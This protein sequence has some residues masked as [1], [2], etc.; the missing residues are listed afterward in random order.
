[1]AGRCFKVEGHYF[2]DIE[3]G[4]R[5]LTKGR[6][7]TETDVV[8]YTNLTGNIEELFYN[9]E[10]IKNESVFKA[11][12]VPTKLLL[13]MADALIIQTCFFSSNVLAFLG[14]D[15][16]RVKAPTFLGDTITVDSEFIAKRETKNKDRGIITTLQKV[17]NQRNEEVLSYK[18]TRMIRRKDA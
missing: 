14:L 5:I 13:A 18:V 3:V 11:R 4:D 10:Y 16:L 12:V 1:M 2:E 8:T 17:M 9:I 7:I 6:T 15:E